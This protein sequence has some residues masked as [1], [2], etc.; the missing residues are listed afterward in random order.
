MNNISDEMLR[1][2]MSNQRIDRMI[3]ERSML[4]QMET[5]AENESLSEAEKLERLKLAKGGSW[6]DGWKPYCMPCP[7]LHR[8]SPKPYGFE[9]QRCG[10]MIGFNLTR[11]RES[12][13]NKRHDSGLINITMQKSRK[14]QTQERAVCAKRARKLRKLGESVIWSSKRNS[15]VWDMPVNLHHYQRNML[16]S[17][18][19]K[20]ELLTKPGLIAVQI[21]KGVGK[22]C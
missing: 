16:R 1:M 19:N 8:M 15:Y 21:T 9:C 22:S 4:Q 17:I 7:G 13:L 18:R 12:P 10:N 3:S 14:P 5:V 2:S 11:L 20:I 6:Y